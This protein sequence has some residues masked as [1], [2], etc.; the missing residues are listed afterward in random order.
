[1]PDRL[2]IGAADVGDHPVQIEQQ[3]GRRKH[4]AEAVLEPDKRVVVSGDGD[5]QPPTAGA[6]GWVGYLQAFAEA[7]IDGQGVALGRSALV[8]A[9]LGAGEA[10]RRPGSW[11]DPSWIFGRLGAVRSGYAARYSH[12]R[13]STQL[14]FGRAYCCQ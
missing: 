4:R 9:D 11:L 5:P 2:A 7:A 1:M 3:C 8:A 13:E 6:E 12:L 14:S 10:N